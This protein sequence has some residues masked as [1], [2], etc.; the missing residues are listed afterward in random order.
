M[1]VAA[2][3]SVARDTRCATASATGN[4]TGHF[5]E[6][7]QGWGGEGPR[8]ELIITTRGAR[9]HNDICRSN[10]IWK[11]GSFTARAPA[12]TAR[13]VNEEVQRRQQREGS[14]ERQR[15]NTDILV[16]S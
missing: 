16:G 14:G 13:I 2:S 11:S 3:V 9:T 6:R 12:R 8:G 10:Y 5:G 4:G 7:D 15:G 1:S